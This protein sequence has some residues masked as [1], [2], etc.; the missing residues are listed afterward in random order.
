MNDFIALDL[1]AA[2]MRVQRQRMQIVA[3][4]L[5]NQD[6]TGP[7]GPYKRKEAVLQATQVDFGKNLSE[8]MNMEEQSIHSVAIAAVSVD[9]APPVK[10]YDPSHPNADAQGYVLKPNVSPIREMTDM[11]DASHAYEANLAAAKATEDMLN[12]AMSLIAK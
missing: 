8:A 10:V 2:G 11:I 9:S 4:N 6:T 3:E 1:S 5:A 7:D 12:A